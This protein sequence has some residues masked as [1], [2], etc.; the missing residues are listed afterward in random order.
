MPLKTVGRAARLECAAAKNFCAGFRDAIRDHADLFGRLHRAWPRGDHDFGAADSHA[1]RQLDHGP[2]RAKRAAGQFVGLRDAHDFA[3]AV[4]HFDVA[5]IK[6][7]RNAHGAQNRLRRARRAMNVESHRHQ[8]VDHVLDLLFFRALLHYDNHF[9][10]SFLLS[11]Q[12]A[13][14]IGGDMASPPAVLRRTRLDR[15]GKP[16]ARR[17]RHKIV[18]PCNA[19]VRSAFFFSVAAVHHGALHRARLIQDALE[20]A[21]DRRVRKRAGIRAHRRVEH[22][23]LAVRLVERV[24]ADVA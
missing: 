11:R 2:L 17:R 20:Q 10:S 1:A 23:F 12:F 3:H 13:S 9:N 24:A 15:G 7:R 14:R 18:R 8:A 22:L 19:I 4:E 5:R 21:A 6:I 16:P